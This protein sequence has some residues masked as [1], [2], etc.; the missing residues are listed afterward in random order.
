MKLLLVFIPVAI[1][2]RFTPYHD[3]LWMFLVTAIGIVPLAHLMGEATEELSE[4][5]GPGI[6]GFLNATFGNAPELIIATMG[7]LKGGEAIEVVKASI[8]GSILGNLLMITGLSMF[9]GGLKREKQTFNPKTVGVT[10]TMMILAVAG[11]MAPSTIYWV[12]SVP[13]L[14]HGAVPSVQVSHGPDGAVDATAPAHPAAHL[15]EAKVSHANVHSLTERLEELSV[16]VS[17]LLIIVYVLCLI[18]SFKT[19]H[20]VLSPPEA[21]IADDGVVGYE[22]E[23][24]PK[25]AVITLFVATCFVAVLSEFLV[26]SLEVAG[27]ALGLNPIFM[28]LVVVSAIGNVAEHASAVMI[29]IKGNMDLTLSI[30]MGSSMQIALFVAPTL[31]LF[32]FATGN[33]VNLVFTPLELVSVALA[34]ALVTALTSDGESNW[35]EGAQL[36]CVY[37][38]LVLAFYFGF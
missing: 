11:L 30:A 23:H 38:I 16:G 25:R 34:V 15:P 6:S 37:L 14:A 13:T 18:Y 1:A 32:S 19:N 21:A 26:G 29:A 8:T 7:V 10:N 35:L 9:L 36:L 12:S 22:G 24:S 17:I 5:T 4:H 33:H 3:S 2:M 28:G 20:D 31:V 27:E